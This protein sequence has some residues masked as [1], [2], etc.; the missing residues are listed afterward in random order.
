MALGLLSMV[1][2]VF[3]LAVYLIPTIV[4]VTRRPVH[5]AGAIVVNILLGWSFIGW[6]VALVLALGSK[7]Y[8]QPYPYYAQPGG[9]QQPG[10]YQQG[11]YQQQYA[12][13]PGHVP[14]PP[15]W[16]TP[17]VQQYAYPP[18]VSDAPVGTTQPYGAPQLPS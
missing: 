11:G 8:N 14:T 9:Y 5:M 12:M 4:A 3:G 17:S 16:G 1:S 2:L 18:S 6:I 7:Q 10:M 13:P 15:A